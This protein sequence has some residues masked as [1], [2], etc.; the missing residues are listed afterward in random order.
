MANS[1]FQSSS[2]LFAKV[3]KERSALGMASRTVETRETPWTASSFSGFWTA[4]KFTLYRPARVVTSMG[5]MNSAA[6]EYRKFSELLGVDPSARGA[7]GPDSS[8]VKRKV[9]ENETLQRD[10]YDEFSNALG[11]GGERRVDGTPEGGTTR[12]DAKPKKAEI[13]PADYQIFDSLLRQ[14]GGTGRK[15]LKGS[16]RFMKRPPPPKV[17]RKQVPEPFRGVGTTGSA[18]NLSQGRPGPEKVLRRPVQFTEQ[19]KADAYAF[20]REEF[21][22]GMHDLNSPQRTGDSLNEEEEDEIDPVRLVTP[23]TRPHDAISREIENPVMESASL[24]SG[25]RRKEGNESPP[26]NS[27]EQTQVG[28]SLGVVGSNFSTENVGAEK[29]LRR[30]TNTF[31]EQEKAAAYAFMREQFGSDMHGLHSAKRKDEVSK[32]QDEEHV[33]PVRL[34]TPPKRPADAISRDEKAGTV[35][36]GGDLESWAQKKDVEKSQ[37]HANMEQREGGE[38]FDVVGSTGSTEG[39]V[40]GQSRPGKILRR[41]TMSTDQEKADAYAFMREEFGSGIHGLHPAT[42]QDDDLKEE[43]EESVEP[44][45]LVTPPKRPA[46]TISGTISENVQNTSAQVGET[47][48]VVGSRSSAAGVGGDQSGSQKI[49]HKATSLTEQA[50]AKAYEF[51]REEFGPG[52]H[53]L[54]PGT[55]K[56]NDMKEEDE[57]PVEP[58]RLVPPPRRPDDVICEGTDKAPVENAELELGLQKENNKKNVASLMKPPFRSKDVKSHEGGDSIAEGPY[59]GANIVEEEAG[60]GEIVAEPLL[61]RPVGRLSLNDKERRTIRLLDNGVSEGKSRPQGLRQKP[62]ANFRANRGGPRRGVNRSVRQGAEDRLDG[63]RAHPPATGAGPRSENAGFKWKRVG[64]ETRS[65]KES[66]AKRAH[67]SSGSDSSRVARKHGG[68]TLNFDKQKMASTRAGGK[69]VRNDVNRSVL[70]V[71]DEETN[72]DGSS[73]DSRG[74]SAEAVGPGEMEVEV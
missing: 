27:I 60:V 50:K 35:A 8:S 51:M 49:L 14:S 57:E 47:P 69:Q 25:A 23:P 68:K 5:D 71:G 61:P 45:R 37:S 38:P 28:E 15:S 17:K 12:F 33:E 65:A 58:V 40:A 11:V 3:Q 9:D 66:G 63:G 20:M 42:Q 43:D 4:H 19:E 53:D 52:I 55:Q 26:S 46:G 30:P 44:V 31:T 41:P 64:Q 21:G 72:V 29:V 18:Q 62:V 6:E 54:H 39:M 32:Q 56:D 70:S 59:M 36:E 16:K 24:G 7:N 1:A 10:A 2:P 13:D 74:T 34:F 73:R 67:R 48:G 22:Y